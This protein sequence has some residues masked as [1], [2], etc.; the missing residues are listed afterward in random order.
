MKRPFLWLIIIAVAV[1][2]LIIL[3]PKGDSA[4][5][6]KTSGAA[7]PV[8]VEGRVVKTTPQ[9]NRINLSGSILSNEEVTLQSQISGIVTS[10]YFTE[11]SHVKKGELLLK[12]D[13]SQF[14]VHLKKDEL[15]EEL[16]NIS[17]ERQKKLLAINA[18][19]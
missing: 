17:E 8:M 16:Y 3:R 1:V 19:A 5:T 10:V 9:S 7:K 18:I 14:Q 12:L 2:L 15:T 11:G 13:D 4:E 6:K